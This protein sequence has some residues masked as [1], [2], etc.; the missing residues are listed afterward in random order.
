LTSTSKSFFEII[1]FTL[2]GENKKRT[3]L[4]SAANRSQRMVGRAAS[5]DWLVSEF[6]SLVGFLAGWLVYVR[7]GLPTPT[8]IFQNV[9]EA[10]G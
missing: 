9:D 10:T 8:S 7:G 5:K 4:E 2:T 6:A 3:L 1:D